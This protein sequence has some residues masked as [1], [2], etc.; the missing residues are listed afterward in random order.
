MELILEWTFFLNPNTNINIATLRFEIIS[1]CKYGNGPQ[2]RGVGCY[3]HRELSLFCNSALL[4]KLDTFM[5]CCVSV[6]SASGDIGPALV[7][8]T[9]SSGG[10]VPF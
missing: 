1:L 4:R 3:E 10:D 5:R 8:A 2:Q 6:G 7:D 9:S